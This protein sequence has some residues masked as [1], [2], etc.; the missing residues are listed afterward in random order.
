M[1]NKMK[2]VT[3]ASLVLVVGLSALSG[4]TTTGSESLANET[5]ESISNKIH[6]GVTTK[7]QLIDML[8]A[9]METTFTDG[10]LEVLTYEYTRLKP[11]A[12]NFIPYN[13]ISQVADAKKKELVVLLDKNSR[14]KNLVMN[15]SDTQKRWGVIE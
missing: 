3:V 6:K 1:G 15:I 4:C 13:V 9:P 2:K 7:Q 11:H 12:Q 8:G 14:V 10:G 5:P